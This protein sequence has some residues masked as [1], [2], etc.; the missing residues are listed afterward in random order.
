MMVAYEGAFTAIFFEALIILVAA[1]SIPFIA[2][3]FVLAILGVDLDK[4]F[5]RITV[6]SV[7]SL[8]APEF[9]VKLA[10]NQSSLK[11]VDVL[12]VS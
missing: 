6:I 2:V 12:A 10:L 11:S 1:P 4:T 5:C 9:S 7:L 3:C 8:G